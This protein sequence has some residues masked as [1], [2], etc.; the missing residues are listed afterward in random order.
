MSRKRVHEI[1]KQQGLTSKEVLAALQAAGI[2]AKAA[3]SS[4]E[5]EVALKVLA[6][7]GGDGAKGD[8]KPAPPAAKPKPATKRSA[9]GKAAATD[10]KREGQP[11]ARQDSGS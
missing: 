8:A 5:E 1:A 9:D 3:A 2:E 6:A 11:A 10:P 7:R 4:V